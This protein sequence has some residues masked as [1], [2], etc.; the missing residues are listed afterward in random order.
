MATPAVVT[1]PMVS[2]PRLVNHRAPSGPLVISPGSS[3]PVTTEMAGTVTVNGPA[4]AE[5]EG[6]VATTLYEKEVTPEGTDPPTAPLVLAM[7]SQ[8]GAP[9]ARA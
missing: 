8:L 6:L 5:P 9:G 3:A 1:R 2:L 4:V 7:A